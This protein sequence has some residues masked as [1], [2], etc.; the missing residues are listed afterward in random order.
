MDN[1]NAG[2][3]AGVEAWE[4]GGAADRTDPDGTQEQ[5]VAT[6]SEIELGPAT[7]GSRA[8]MEL[9][10]KMRRGGPQQNDPKHGTRHD[11][12]TAGTDGLA[13]MFPWEGLRGPRAV[14]PQQHGDDG[15]ERRRVD[16][17]DGAGAGGGEDDADRWPDRRR[18]RGSD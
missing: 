5:A 4:K 9:A 16:E 13:D 2:G 15:E 10:K 12:S 8:Q 6:G 3:Q 18:G 11:V 7:R 1:R 14:P 17:E